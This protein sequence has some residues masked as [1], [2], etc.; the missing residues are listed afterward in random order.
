MPL[1][2][3]IC[4][5][6]ALFA[7]GLKSLLVKEPSIA[8]SGIF[9][10]DS[11]ASDLEK[12][13]ALQ[14]D[15]ILLDYT[16]DTEELLNIP[17]DY[18][19]F[20]RTKIVIIGDK[21]TKHLVTKRLHDL[22]LRGVVGI[23]P[24]SADSDILKKALRAILHGELWLDRETLIKLL[25][26][27][28]KSSKTVRLAR[29]EKDIV[30]YICRGYRNREIAEKLQISEHTVKSHCHRIYKKLGVTDRLQ[31]ALH[32]HRIFLDRLRAE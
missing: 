1:R 16:V 29:R 30:A 11:L 20:S 19:F 3:A 23:L 5:S 27:L 28:Q 6:N 15:V 18:F 25:A 24:P 26:F 17:D 9:A 12:A 13:R 10:G 2:I 14:P 32:S 7:E 22:L 21:D 31:L 8:I 4:V